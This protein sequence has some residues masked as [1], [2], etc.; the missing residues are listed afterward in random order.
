MLLWLL[1]SWHQPTCS[2]PVHL[3]T[4]LH[5]LDCLVAQCSLRYHTL[6]QVV[7]CL[8]I[9][10][11]CDRACPLKV[12]QGYIGT[13]LPPFTQFSSA[14]ICVGCENINIT[15]ELL[16]IHHWTYLWFML[17]QYSHQGDQLFVGGPSSSSL[18]G[19]SQ[20]LLIHVRRS[21]S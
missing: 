5:G 7:P 11:L 9:P 15:V 8:I 12:Q 1:R 13:L 10:A 20:P 17:L 2:I 4:N 3:H 19:T 18:Y 21:C 6:Q 14:N 16:K